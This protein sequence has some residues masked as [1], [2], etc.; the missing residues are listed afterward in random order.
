MSAKRA[1]G[2]V[3]EGEAG[4]KAKVTQDAGGQSV[5][6]KSQVTWTSK[7]LFE[8]SNSKTQYFVREV[9]GRRMTT[10]M[11]DVDVDMWSPN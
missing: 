1:K 8:K 2:S 5:S 6:E 9:K 10:R 7:N 11:M 4:K 3:G